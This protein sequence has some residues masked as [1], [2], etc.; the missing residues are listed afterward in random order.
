MHLGGTR[1]PGVVLPVPPQAPS[2]FTRPDSPSIL[3][4]GTQ[5]S[6]LTHLGQTARPRASQSSEQAK[7]LGPEASRLLPSRQTEGLPQQCQQRKQVSFLPTLRLQEKRVTASFF[8]FPHPAPKTLH[9]LRRGLMGT[10]N[11]LA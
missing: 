6:H 9:S 4:C 8:T 11:S 3:H 10:F 2:S 1:G 5:P 7:L